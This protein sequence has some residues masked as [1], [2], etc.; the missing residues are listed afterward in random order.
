ML[1][2]RFWRIFPWKYVLIRPQERLISWAHRPPKREGKRDIFS[3]RSRAKFVHFSKVDFAL[4]SDSARPGPR[5][6][7]LPFRCPVIFQGKAT[8]P[9]KQFLF[10]LLRG[11]RQLSVN[12]FA[13]VQQ[14]R[15]EIWI[16]WKVPWVSGDVMSRGTRR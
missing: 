15:I 12:V 8:V 11:T 4:P 9:G 1:R 10:F 13:E 6:P 14:T 5:P 16:V 3:G 7:S 2:G